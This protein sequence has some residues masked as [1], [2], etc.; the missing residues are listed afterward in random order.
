VG[1]PFPLAGVK[2]LD[3][4][5][6]LSGPYV[7]RLLSDLGAEVVKVEV[8]GTDITQVFGPKPHGHTGLY[9]QTNTGKKN[10]S[11]NLGTEDGQALLRDLA[12]HAH[13]VIENF[14]PGTMKRLN[15]GWEALTERNQ[16]LVLLSISGFGQWGPEANR[17]AYAPVVHAESG[18][19]GRQAEADG[20]TPVDIQMSLADSVSGLHGM[21][22]ILAALRVAEQTGV[23]Q[24]IDLSMFEAMLATDDYVNYSV[25]GNPVTSA[26]GTIYQVEGR[27]LM[28]AGDLKFLWH[29]LST[30]HGLIDPQPKAPV[31]EKIVNRHR[32]IREFIEGFTARADAIAALEK[33]GVAY[34]EVRTPSTLLDS[35]TAQA[36]EVVAQVDDRNG[37]T[38]PV[39]R[40]PYRFSAASSAPQGG[41]AYVGEHNTEVLADW[42]GRTPDQVAALERSGALYPCEQVNVH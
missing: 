24:H 25:N 23:G 38:R 15:V 14:R 9:T 33:A 6:A 30:T 31:E 35:P 19:L 1:G 29:R 26:R 12:A 20:T 40:M 10:I 41:P 32:I 39:I 17:Q 5:R 8:P 16:S 2:V 11:I 22:A 37:G 34:A 13:V 18:L 4:S 27:P 7:G 42:L 21:V 3:L 36:R 28:V